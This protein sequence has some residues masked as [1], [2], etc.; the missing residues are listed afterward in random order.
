MTFVGCPQLEAICSSTW[1][2]VLPYMYD[3]IQ[4]S[5]PI[6][7][8]LY[9]LNYAS[10]G[11]MNPIFYYLPPPSPII[12]PRIV[13]TVTITYLTIRDLYNWEARCLAL[14]TRN[15]GFKNFFIPGGTL[16]TH[17]VAPKKRHVMCDL[18]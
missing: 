1:N 18:L 14:R 7:S 9:S 8:E 16:T 4:C 13:G 3:T 2:Y 11:F 10:K 15:D 5:V 6:G 12:I 17:L